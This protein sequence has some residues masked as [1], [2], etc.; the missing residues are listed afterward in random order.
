M[1]QVTQEIVTVL[2]QPGKSETACFKLATSS[3]SVEIASATGLNS[4]E[5]FAV[6]GWR[7]LPHGGR[8]LEPA[9]P[10]IYTLRL[11][12]FPVGNIGPLVRNP[13]LVCLLLHM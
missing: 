10:C 9:C 4:A 7:C 5:H 3:I 8:Y 11:C 1:V 2:L 12:S 6:P 13:S